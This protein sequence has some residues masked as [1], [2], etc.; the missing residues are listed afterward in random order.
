MTKLTPQERDERRAAEREL[1]KQAIES[2]RT[3][4]GWQAWLTTRSRFHK[5]SFGNQILIAWQRPTAKQVTGFKKWIDLGYGVR[6]GE[7]AIKIWA[8]CQPSKKQM[9]EWR[10][11]GEIP[12]D[13]PRMWFRLVPVFAD[14]QIEPLPDADPKPLTPPIAEVEG[15]DLDIHRGDLIA[16]AAEIGSGVDYEDLPDGTGGYYRPA[17]KRIVIGHAD[18][19]NAEIRVLVHELAH[20][21][22]RADKDKDDPALSYAQEEL[23][24]ES[25]ALS[26]CGTLGF[27]ISGSS[28]PYLTS[29][30]TTTD[31]TIID[32]AAKLVNRLASRIEDSITLD[33]VAA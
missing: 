11:A 26:V 5:Y 8:P 6:K 14:D 10:E 18:S 16:L 23:V 25:V 24:V 30:S 19:S 2:L 1:V 28:V 27:D 21:L 32:K 29:W 3:S 12:A 22:V 15:D 33:A 20:A 17:D 9:Q 13:R 7:K 4:E 31:L